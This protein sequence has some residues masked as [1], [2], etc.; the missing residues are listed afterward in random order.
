MTAPSSP[1]RPGIVNI[2]FWLVLVGSVLLLSGGLLGLSVAVSAEDA[3]FGKDVSPETVQN[4]R[5]LL[6]G[7]SVLWA[8]VGMALSFLAGRA[9]N[10]DL[11]FRRSVVVMAAA[12]VLMVFLLTLLA[13]FTI[14]L[15]TLFGVVPVAIGAT[16]FMRPAATDWFL[17]MQ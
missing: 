15:P 14:T 3:V 11:R 10:G 13:P 6:G 4:L 9:R 8:V 2:A 16:L 5:I 12:V 7:L 17:D 1:A